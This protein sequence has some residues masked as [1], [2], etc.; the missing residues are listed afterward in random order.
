[1]DCVS[2]RCGLYS[3]NVSDCWASIDGIKI[4]IVHVKLFRAFNM[5]CSIMTTDI[6]FTYENMDLEEIQLF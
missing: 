1:M 4:I 6:V 3:G 5:F 2:R